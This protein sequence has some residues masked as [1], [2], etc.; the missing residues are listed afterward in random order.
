MRRQDFGQ[1][2][3]GFGVLWLRDER[4]SLSSPASS[5]AAA[6]EEPFPSAGADAVRVRIHRQDQVRRC[7]RGTVPG[8]RTEVD[9]RWVPGLALGGSVSTAPLSAGG[10]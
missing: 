2:I 7:S 4:A 10:M 9:A 3:I 5:P 1:V 8:P 6:A